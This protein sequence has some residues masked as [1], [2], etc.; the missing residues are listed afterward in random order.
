MK[1][2]SNNINV[3][4]KIFRLTQ[5]QL[6]DKIGITRQQIGNYE[7]GIGTIPLERIIIFH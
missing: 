2:I 3:F 1:K 4:K 7:I 5:G 6:G